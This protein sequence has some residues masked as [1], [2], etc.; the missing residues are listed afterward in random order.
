VTAR[1]QLKSSCTPHGTEAQND[2]SC[3]CPPRVDRT[4]QATRICSGYLRI[5]VLLLANLPPASRLI[6]YSIYGNPLPPYLEFL[7][8]RRLGKDRVRVSPY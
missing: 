8:W 4:S 6:S 2:D 1:C 5:A 3:H 7:T